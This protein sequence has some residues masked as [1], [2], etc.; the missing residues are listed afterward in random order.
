MFGTKS[1][2][3]V[4]TIGNIC[5]DTVGLHIGER[6]GSMFGGTIVGSEGWSRMTT[7]GGGVSGATLGSGLTG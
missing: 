1:G 4:A 2:I 5:G 3:C 7:L 6:I